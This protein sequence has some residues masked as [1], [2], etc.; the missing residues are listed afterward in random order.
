[1]GLFEISGRHIAHNKMYIHSMAALQGKFYF[2][3]SPN[4]L[5]TFSIARVPEPHLEL[6]TFHTVTP[7]LISDAPHVVT[8]SC[9]NPT[10]SCFSSAFSTSVATS[11]ASRR[12]EPIVYGLL[13]A[14][15]PVIP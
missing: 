15:V 13:Q 12:S 11:S 9:W 14:M 3:E 7:R 2:F 5:G 10:R 1:M 6:A 8:L 4:V